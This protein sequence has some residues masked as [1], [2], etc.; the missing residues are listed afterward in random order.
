[1]PP[2]GSPAF[3]ANDTGSYKYLRGARRD[4]NAF[5][6]TDGGGTTRL[7]TFSSPAR[8]AEGSEG[9]RSKQRNYN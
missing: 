3:V 6:G 4:L 7:F 8:P 1:M 9:A 2:N 5:T